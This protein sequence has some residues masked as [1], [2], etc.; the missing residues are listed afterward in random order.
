MDGAIQ[1]VRERNSNEVQTISP[2]GPNVSATI[3]FSDFT[4]GVITVNSCFSA[5]GYICALNAGTRVSIRKIVGNDSGANIPQ[6]GIFSV[7]EEGE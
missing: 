1:R 4:T 5:N 3:D 7:A 2:F 6:D